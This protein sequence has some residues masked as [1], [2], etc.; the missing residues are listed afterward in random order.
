MGNFY[1]NNNFIYWGVCTSHGHISGVKLHGA[2][3]FITPN[4]T[5]ISRV[6]KPRNELFEIIKERR[7]LL[8]LLHHCPCS[9]LHP[10]GTGGTAMLG[11]REYL[12]IPSAA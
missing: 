8:Y 3:G 11:C 7:E 5:R 4:C 6:W 12:K 2:K 1:A 10:A 9:Q